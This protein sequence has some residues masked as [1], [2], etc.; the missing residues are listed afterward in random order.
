MA[1]VYEQF[2]YLPAGHYEIIGVGPEI[3]QGKF[4][5]LA[6]FAT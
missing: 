2:S 3:H 4:L 1:D 6:L 5:L